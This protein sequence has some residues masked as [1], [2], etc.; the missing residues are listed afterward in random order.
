MPKINTKRLKVK[1]KNGSWE[2]VAGFGGGVYPTAKTEGMTQPVGVDERGRLFTEPTGGGEANVKGAVRY[3]VAQ[4]LT[5]E[6]KE[7]ARGNIGAVSADEVATAT[8]GKITSPDTATVGDMLTVE[9]VDENGKPVKWKTAK[10]TTEV[11]ESLPNPHKLTFSGA[12]EAEYD[13]SAE[14]EVEIPTAPDTYTKAEIDTAL[15]EVKESIPEA[16]DVPE[17]FDWAKS[18]LPFTADQIS[19]TYNAVASC[20][21]TNPTNFADGIPYFRYH[22]GNKNFTWTNPNPHKGAVSVTVLSWQQWGKTS[23]GNSSALK[24]CYSDGSTEIKTPKNGVTTTFTSKADKVLTQIKGN[25]DLENWILLDLSVLKIVAQ[26]DPWFEDSAN[27]AT[28][29]TESATDVQYPSA[30]AVYTKF[31]EVETALGSYITDVDTLIGGDDN[32]DS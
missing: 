18:E 26:Y 11:P 1:K 6:E 25:Y 27:K 10:P 7:R 30:K 20:F 24:F 14:V 29:L 5:E 8:E 17:V 19:G 13:G 21:V 32:A 9:E 3:D 23:T 15:D 31:A 28:E 12:V 16:V 22:A 2:A 4:E